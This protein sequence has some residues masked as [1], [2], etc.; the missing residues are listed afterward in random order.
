MKSVLSMIVMLLPFS[1]LATGN[2]QNQHQSQV[3]VQDQYQGQGQIAVGG[4]AQQS[5]GN[6]QSVSVAGG[7]TNVQR[8]IP[9][10]YAP[11]LTTTLNDTCMGSASLGLGFA[12]GVVTLGKTYVDD[13]CVRRLHS[14]RVQDLGQPEIAMALMCGNEDV[15]QA[16]LQ[17]GRRESCFG[18]RPKALAESYEWPRRV[19]LEESAA[20]AKRA[21]EQAAASVARNAAR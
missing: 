12:S 11:G 7:H 19:T 5:Q 2:G 16:A 4:S 3:Q 8:Q 9:N 14:R 17:S 13:E 6:S 15:Y 20:I 18:G 1:V 21:Q 10:V